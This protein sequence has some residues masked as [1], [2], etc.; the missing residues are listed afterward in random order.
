MVTGTIL[1]FEN[2]IFGKLISADARQ[3]P[4]EDKGY[5]FRFYLGPYGNTRVNYVPVAI[6][7][8]QAIQ[9]RLLLLL[10]R[11]LLFATLTFQ[12]GL[13]YRAREHLRPS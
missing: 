5:I 2:G 11:Q 3:I 6:R 4:M 8:L 10:F 12:E 7:L 1:V 13:V 9:N